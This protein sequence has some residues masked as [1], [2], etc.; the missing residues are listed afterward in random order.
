MAPSLNTAS[1]TMRMVGK[2]LQQSS[3]SAV[4]WLTVCGASTGET[5][6]ALRSDFQLASVLSSL[7]ISGYHLAQAL[8]VCQVEQNMH[9]VL[10]TL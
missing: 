5:T 10:C 1:S 7:T 9:R 6:S 3:Q 8:A 4:M 2:Y